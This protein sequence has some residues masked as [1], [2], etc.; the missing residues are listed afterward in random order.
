MHRLPAYIL[1]TQC[2]GSPSTYYALYAPAPRVHIMHSM[3]RLPAYMLCTQCTGSLSTY[4]ALNAKAVLQGLNRTEFCSVCKQ[5]NLATFLSLH[6]THYTCSLLLLFFKNHQL[7]RGL[8]VAA[9]L[10]ICIR[11]NQNNV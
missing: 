9:Q 5:K 7:N 10:W 8:K 6:T 1:C 11:Q 4:Y 2:T 3:H